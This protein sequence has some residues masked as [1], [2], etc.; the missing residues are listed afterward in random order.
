MKVNS[1]ERISNRNISKLWTEKKLNEIK[2][3]GL[4]NKSIYEN[5]ISEDNR[6]SNQK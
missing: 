6:E 4:N 2:N 3:I 5:S 1:S